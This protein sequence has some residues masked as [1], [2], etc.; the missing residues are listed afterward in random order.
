MQRNPNVFGGLS[1]VQ[2]LDAGCDQRGPSGLMAGAQAFAGVAVEVL[3][4]QHLVAPQR[5]ALAG[6][7]GGQART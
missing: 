6:L 1:P 7:S 3:V 4:E 2:L 5:V